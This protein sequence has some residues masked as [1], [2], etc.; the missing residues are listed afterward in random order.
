MRI[1]RRWQASYRVE[2]IFVGSESVEYDAYN[3]YFITDCLVLI[4]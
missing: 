1:P 3:Y 4:W 2:I